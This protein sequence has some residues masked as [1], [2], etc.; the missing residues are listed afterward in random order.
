MRAFEAEM[1]RRMWFP[2]ARV[3]DVGPDRPFGAQLLGRRLVVFRSQDRIT[4]AADRCPHRGARLSQGRMAGG[5]LECPYHGW[6][7][8]SDGSCALVPSQPGA[9]PGAT[10]ETL[11]ARERFGLV[12]ATHELP[13]TDLPTIPETADEEGG[14]EVGLGAWFD[15]ACGLRTITENFRDSSHFAFVH[16]TTFG[17]VNPEVP[18]Y[19]VRAERLRLEWEM[20][21]TFGSQWSSLGGDGDRGS[22]YRFGAT[23]GGPSP[24]GDTEQVLLHYRFELPSLAY[25]F[26]EHEGGARRLVCQAAAPLDTEGAASRVFFFVAADA[27]FREGQGGVAR[28]VEIE[29]KVFSEDVPIV[30]NLDPAEAPLELEGQAHV[31]ADRYSI[32]YRRLYREMLDRF[33]ESRERGVPFEVPASWVVSS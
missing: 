26:T 28:Q 17:D 2:V 18:A 5:T 33:R 10:L 25:V 23:D 4:V 27:G 14:W 9:H 32:A 8:G 24:N 29:A 20:P 16:R 15:V 6:R 7:W 3:Q 12:W 19:T 22:K 21:I 31:R 13:L 30:E 11:P 1:L